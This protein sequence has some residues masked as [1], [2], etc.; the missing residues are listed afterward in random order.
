MK[1]LA[2]KCNKVFMSKSGLVNCNLRARHNSGSSPLMLRHRRKNWLARVGFGAVF[3]TIAVV[4]VGP[5]LSYLGSGYVYWLALGVY[6]GI[7]AVVDWAGG[8]FDDVEAR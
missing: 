4:F 8:K 1:G 2:M 7:Y 3:L 6:M 5:V